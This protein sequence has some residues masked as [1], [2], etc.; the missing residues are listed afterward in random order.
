MSVRRVIQGAQVP[1]KIWTDDVD[2][3]SL[4]QLREI[5]SLPL[6]HHH[7]A[8]MPDVHFGKGATV[9]SVIPTDRAIIPAAVGV[10]I[11][12]GMTAARLSLCTED[13]PDSLSTVRAA[14]ESRVP[15]GTGG[16]R[17]TPKVKAD[18]SLLCAYR[19][20]LERNPNFG[21][22]DP[23]RVAAQIGT[24]GSG[25]HFI[26]LCLDETGCVW[27]MLHSGSRGVGHSIGTHFIEHAKREM[28][29]WHIHLPNRDLAYLPEGTDGFDRYI[30]A[31][32]WAQ[33]Y[34]A[35][36]R[37]LLLE[38]TIEGLR[39]TLP[40]FEIEDEVISA[41]HNY[42]EREHHFGRDVWLTRKGA[43]RAREGDLGIIPG[44]MGTRSYIV[45]GRGNPDSFCSCSHGAGRQ[46][47]RSEAKRRFSI[48]DLARET[49]GIECRKDAGV[50]DEIPS[51]YK[52]IERVMEYQ[53]DLV[54]IVHTLQQVVNVK[55]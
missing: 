46:L 44:S 23:A 19:D 28:E 3:A 53:D 33:A 17:Q 27:V 51:A 31:V 1:I 7:V 18:D 32:S 40:P 45:R 12:C 55:G 13:L 50:I 16:A 22:P 34:A 37:D 4:D 43:I 24:L 26:E 9:G 14:I 15:L 25:N 47:S 10:D 20:L 38:K 2:S 52:D 6:I 48:E 29:R 36:N 49:D 39:E 11:G 41:H 8:A 54:E 42:V 21:A 30:E 35:R 5:A